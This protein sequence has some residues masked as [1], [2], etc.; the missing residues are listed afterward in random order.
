MT[1]GRS[2]RTSVRPP[3]SSP[4]RAAARDGLGLWTDLYQIT[5]AVAYY[6]NHMMQPATFELFVRSLP[7]ERGYLVAA[8]IDEA[9]DYL[10]ALHFD[11]T[12]IEYLRS[13]PALRKAPDGFFRWLRRLRFTGQVRAVA[14]GTPVFALE[15]IVQVTAPLPEAQIVETY[16]LSVVNFQTTV[17]SKA[18]RIVEAARGRPVVDFGFRRAHGPNAAVSAARAAYIAGCAGTSNVAAGRKYGI[19]VFGTVSHAFVMACPSES[20]AFR[21]YRRAFKDETLLLVDTYDTIGGVNRAIALGDTI[22][23]VRLDSGDLL[24]LS[25]EVRRI[26]DQAGYRET[27]I[28]ASGNLNEFR[29]AELLDAGAPIDMFGVGTDLVTSRDAPA[30]EGIYK[31]VEVGEG[32]ER[33]CLIKTSSGKETLPGRKQILRAFDDDGRAAGDRLARAGEPPRPGEEP[34]LRLVMRNGRRA[35]RRAGIERIRAVARD[36]VARLREDVRALRAP[37]AYPVTVSERL[38]ELEAEV[39]REIAVRERSP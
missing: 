15:P 9:L 13:Q 16:L 19:P 3:A 33:R 10:E 21:L 2:R 24:A 23:G 27:K 25:R 28:V 20:E 6:Q 39:R 8:G 37:A 34:L 32:S 30:L 31:L 12:D 14:E 4:T 11:A 22:K 7:A 29:I 35:G 18:S 26:L 17:A 36:G 1:A 5:T 38:A